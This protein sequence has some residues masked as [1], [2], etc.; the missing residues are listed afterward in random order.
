MLFARSASARIA[1]SAT[2]NA[3][4]SSLRSSRTSASSRVSLG[5]AA[6]LRSAAMA[7]MA[8]PPTNG[9]P[10][11]VTLRVPPPALREIGRLAS[12]VDELRV[13]DAR[14]DDGAE[15]GEQL[16]VALLE[17]ARARAG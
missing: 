10:V 12:R 5:R 16:D 11:S 13:T 4:R 3:P 7:P 8:R 1:L 2:S 6:G 15:R 14:G 9:R 17:G